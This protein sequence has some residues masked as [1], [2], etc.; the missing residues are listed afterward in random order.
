MRV[1]ILDEP[2]AV[3]TPNE[4]EVL[5]RAMKALAADGRAIVFVSHKLNEV[6]AVSSTVTVLRDGKVV[7]TVDTAAADERML[8]RLMVE[9]ADDA[10]TE[11]AVESHQPV[12]PT[13][14]TAADGPVACCLEVRDLEVADDRGHVAVRGLSVHVDRGEIV[15]VVG[16]AGNGQ[17]E[18]AEAIAGIRQAAGGS[19]TING[20]DVTRTTVR[21]RVERGLAFI[22]EDRMSMG[23]AAGLAIEDNLL[24]RSYWRA[25]AAGRGL[26]HRNRMRPI[27]RELVERYGIRGVRPGFPI[28]ILSGGNVQRVIL[29]REL[30]G[31]PAV[32]V[33]ASPCRGLDVHAAAAVR[34]VLA[35][36]RDQGC[37][38]LLISEDLDELLAL[39]DRL[40]VIYEGAVAAELDPRTATPEQLGLLMAGVGGMTLI[41]SPPPPR[42][43]PR[44]AIVIE[45]RAFP[46][47]TVRALVAL[48]SLAGALAVGALLLLVTGSDPWTAYGTILD[49]SFGSPA[50]FSQT[51]VQ[52]TPLILTALATIV[53]YRLRLW[54]IGMDGQLIIG[55]VC[56]S[57]VALQFGANAPSSVAI[58]ASFTA[59][60]LGGMAWS[61]IAGVLRAYQRTNEVISTLMLNFIAL[62]LIDY[63]VVDTASLWRDPL[64]A[65]HPQGA[66]LPDAVLLP[67]LF[68][69]AD[70]GI[71]IAVVAAILV[72][73]MLRYSVWGYKA[74]V[75]GD[76]E[77][78]AAYAGIDARRVTVAAF[79]L[80]G[81][82][83]G[84]AGAIQVTNV[85]LSLDKAGL[86]PGLGL[87]YTGIVVAM[88]V[89]LQPLVVRA[90]WRS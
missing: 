67:L 66:P 88:L 63:L 53:V 90:R 34:T 37:G 69:Q 77:G 32:I 58:V 68:D 51:L 8:A 25:P 2:T 36:Q 38:V 24:L 23:V 18:L 54:S 4:T 30:A 16:V 59:G 75:L 50:A 39:S 70:L 81:A 29:A 78:A 43:L 82:L 47:A 49:S 84:L 76:S 17:R 52:T 13:P 41:D 79:A 10:E 73:L 7:A 87:G 61:L 31:S 27:G 65:G 1:L 14:A 28:R 62:N 74:S 72:W 21:A 6:L 40:V 20:D 15:G 85:T 60:V 86:T 71:V 44:R 33:A 46:T 11:V 55:A 9:R 19:V 80:S 22:P 83:C 3:L 5:F 42:T 12:R 26:L 89:R 64:S 57:G 35:D 45:P 56:A 48:G